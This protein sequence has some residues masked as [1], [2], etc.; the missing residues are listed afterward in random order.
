MQTNNEPFLS[1]RDEDMAEIEHEARRRVPAYD[2]VQ[3]CFAA[4][5]QYTLCQGEYGAE[6]SACAAFGDAWADCVNA[7]LCPDPFKS[8]RSC[9]RDK[10]PRACGT[11]MYGLM[12][13]IRETNDVINAVKKEAA[14][15]LLSKEGGT[16]PIE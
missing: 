7:A 16:G 1:L 9:V 3:Q 2:R 5:Q 8:L 12:K 4:H 10:D 14:Q 15:R 13:C 11:E 6:S